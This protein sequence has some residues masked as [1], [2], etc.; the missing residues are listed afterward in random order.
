MAPE[1]QGRPTNS[2]SVEVDKTE[3]PANFSTR[4]N[5]RGTELACVVVS[6]LIIA[7]VVVCWSVTTGQRLIFSS[8]FFAALWVFYKLYAVPKKLIE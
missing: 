1:A 4:L 7:G 6:I 2:L 8:M 3:D 5:Y